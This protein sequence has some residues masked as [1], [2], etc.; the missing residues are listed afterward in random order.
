MNL[1]SLL[2][3]AA[4]T[5]PASP[6]LAVGRTTVATYEQ[7]ARDA[8]ALAGGLDRAGLVP[9][10]RVALVMRN[11]PEFVTTQCAAWHAGLVVVPINTRPRDYRFVSNLPKNNYGKVVKIELR[12]ALNREADLK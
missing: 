11:C 7:L 4:R 6:A 1:A 3:R 8:A 5:L 2:H 12:A 9:G 10:D